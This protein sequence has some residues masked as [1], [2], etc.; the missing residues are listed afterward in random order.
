MDAINWNEVWEKFKGDTTTLV[1]NIISIILISVIGKLIL[2]FISSH[3]QKLMN[4]GQT[5]EDESKGKA[6]VTSM[7]IIRSVSRYIIYFICIVLILNVLGFGSSVNNILVTAGV[8]SLIISLG[9]QNIIRDMLAGL[10]ILFERQY[11]VGDFVKIG[12]YTG[13]VTSI[14]MRLTYLT[15]IDGQKVII[16]NGQIT[17]VVN[18]GN[19]YNIA[20]L[21]IPTPYEAN[22]RE[23]ISLLEKLVTEYYEKN[24]ELFV[25]APTVLGISA[26]NNSSVDITITA[27][28]VSLKQWQVERELRL[29][30]KE[31]FDR[32]GISIPY[33]QVDVSIKNKA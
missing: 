6:L 22:T 17:Q 19:T 28:T 7:T 27:Q 26:F 1:V 13:R 5:M 18:Y 25:A 2:N 11:A 32:Q 30:I 20:R 33:Q 14:A 15:N 8:G 12:D 29:K 4:K 16:P 21:V 3:T 9:A 10:F 24:K 23:V 31:E